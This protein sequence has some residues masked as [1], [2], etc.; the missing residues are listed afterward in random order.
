MSFFSYV[1][2]N[3]PHVKK[4]L[5]FVWNGDGWIRIEENLRYKTLAQGSEK[6]KESGYL[7]SG[8]VLFYFPF[9]LFSVN[10]YIHT[11]SVPSIILFPCFRIHLSDFFFPLLIILE[12]TVI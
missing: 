10:G 1:S 4:L 12:L 5:I 3:S 6:N 7:A 9:L 11:Y 2:Y 8:I